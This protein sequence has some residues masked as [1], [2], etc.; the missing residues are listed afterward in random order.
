MKKIKI[1]G[2]EGAIIDSICKEEEEH[3]TI[4]S[5]NMPKR[6]MEKLANRKVRKISGSTIY[7]YPVKLSRNLSITTEIRHLPI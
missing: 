7:G 2:I 5:I 4:L 1:Q 6:Y 3:K